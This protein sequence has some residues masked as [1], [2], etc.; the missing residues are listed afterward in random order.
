MITMDKR[1]H[2]YSCN[3]NR[4]HFFT[5]ILLYSLE[6]ELLTQMV[7]WKQISVMTVIYP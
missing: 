4:N 7:L 2:G 6:L 1:L 3:R 5:P